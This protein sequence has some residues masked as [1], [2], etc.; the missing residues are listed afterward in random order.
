M[1]YRADPRDRAKSLAMVVVLHAGLG[2]ALVFGLAGDK[3]REVAES[4]KSFD[5]REL[6]PPPEPEPPPKDESDSAQKDQAAPP[7]LRAK[8]APVVAPK[9]PHPLPVP[10][11]VRTSDERAPI[12]G[13]DRSAGAAAV[14]GPGSGAGG[15]GSGSGFGGGGSGGAGS[16][17][18]GLGREARYVPGSARSR[19]P[20][21]IIMTAPSPTGR[22]PL[23]LSIT[24]QGRVGS[25][26]PLSTSGSTRLDAELCRSVS[27]HSRWVPATDR[28]GRPITVELVFNATWSDR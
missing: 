3:V 8:P 22:L 10:S 12:E 13:A 14:A 11:P 27:A 21:S 1:A 24:P 25:C 7:D 17:T 4:L 2:A 6:P 15:S 28:S 16:G 19:L 23:R 20:H 5:V 26:V 18:G 9:P